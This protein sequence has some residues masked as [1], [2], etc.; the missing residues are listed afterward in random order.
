MKALNFCINWLEMLNSL[1]IGIG[2]SLAWMF[3]AAM[4]FTIVL[5]VFFR[6]VLDNALPWPEEI[7]RALMIWMMALVAANAY[8]EGS[9]VAID[10]LHHYL[11][12]AVSRALKI[13]LL[14]V[15]ML[16]LYQLLVLGLEFFQRGFRTRA[17]TFH[18]SRAWIYLA[19]PV[20]FG[21]MLLVN[22]ELVLKEVR[23][24]CGYKAID[25][26]VSSAC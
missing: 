3:V 18:L 13:A 26:E 7:A 14:L 5:Q 6:Y 15:A 21:S 23:I 12:K 10:M 8:R 19:M 22:I 16:V 4:V 1:I 2:R 20:C 9:F 11:P 24:L 17:A 25:D